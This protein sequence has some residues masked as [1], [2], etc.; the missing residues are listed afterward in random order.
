MHNVLRIQL[1]KWLGLKPEQARQL[2]LQ[3]VQLRE[4]SKQVTPEMFVTLLND[5]DV[6]YNQSEQ[7]NNRLN[8]ALEISTAES[9]RLNDSLRSSNLRLEQTLDELAKLVRD[10]SSCCSRKMP[11]ANAPRKTARARRPSCP[12]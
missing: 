12:P 9:N 4:L 7:Q 3:D 2:D 10:L 11:S 1:R 6:S 5:I 8:R